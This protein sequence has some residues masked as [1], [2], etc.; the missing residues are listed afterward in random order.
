MLDE[1]CEYK[2]RQRN[3]ASATQNPAVSIQ[4][5]DL[6]RQF[7]IL[8]PCGRVQCVSNFQGVLRDAYWPDRAL[9]RRSVLLE[10]H[11]GGKAIWRRSQRGC[12]SHLPGNEQMEQVHIDRTRS[13]NA[14]AA[15]VFWP[16]LPEFSIFAP[17]RGNARDA[18][19]GIPPASR[20]WRHVGRHNA[21]T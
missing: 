7:W 4:E 19:E 5:T 9:S 21:R 18:S 3:S 1:R 17:A 14:V 13:S 20:A 2:T 10:G 11:R 15:R 12:D 8:N 16:D 6:A